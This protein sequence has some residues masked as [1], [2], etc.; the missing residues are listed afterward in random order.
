MK[1][2]KHWWVVAVG[3]VMT[4]LAWIVGKKSP[5]VLAAQ[6]R[7]NRSTRRRAEGKL[8]DA[9]LKERQTAAEAE[10]STAL[11][12]AAETQARIKRLDT[13]AHGLTWSFR[14]MRGASDD[15]FADRLNSDAAPARRASHG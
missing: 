9:K 5:S 11:N 13:E 8:K 10:A 3:V 12:G 2:S 14:A 7:A 4:L 1:W 6:M 15:D